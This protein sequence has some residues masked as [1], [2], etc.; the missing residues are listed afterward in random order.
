MPIIL[1]TQ[2]AELRRIMLQNQPQDKQFVK[3]YPK[4]PSQKRTRGL[5]Q[6]VGS[7]FQP[8]YWKKMRFCSLFSSLNK[9]SQ[10]SH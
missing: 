4:N 6:A 9:V 3:P 2:E 10:F 1:A 8:K 7:E 5:A